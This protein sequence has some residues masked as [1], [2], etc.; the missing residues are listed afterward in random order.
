MEDKLRD[1]LPRIA[2]LSWH[3]PEDARAN[4]SAALLSRILDAYPKDRLLLVARRPAMKIARRL[5]GKP[6]AY[7]APDLRR[8]GFPSWWLPAPAG[9]QRTAHWFDWEGSAEMARLVSTWSI[10]RFRPDL[11]WVFLHG[12]LLRW[13]RRVVADVG[14]PYHV[15]VHDD[16]PSLNRGNTYLSEELQREAEAEFIQLYCG[17]ASRDVACPGMAAYY[18][19][20]FGV[21]AVA[22]YNAGINADAIGPYLPR[23]LDRCLRIGFGGNVYGLPGWCALLNALGNL[24]KD[25]VLESAELVLFTRSSTDGWQVPEGVMVTRREPMPE[26]EWIQHLGECDLL[27][28]PYWFDSAQSVMGRTSFPGKL[29][30][31][32]QKARPVLFSAPEDASLAQFF[33][34]YS[35]GEYVSSLQPSAAEAALR[36]MM[37]YTG[38]DL[39]RIWSEWKR[40]AAGDLNRQVLMERLFSTLRQ[41]ASK[42]S[43]HREDHDN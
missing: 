23:L 2:I 28:I 33:R 29:F 16:P 1:C 7:T 39:H 4:A 36:R 43:C 34:Q 20:Q 6:P 15:S 5:L 3:I 27:F 21:G 41:S 22:F 12:P 31:Y 25:D 32:A 9:L 37:A 26:N 35:V 13:A 30:A 40:A 42:Q 8:V 11:V 24:V 18:R 17:A 38:D 19:E 10:R 14:V